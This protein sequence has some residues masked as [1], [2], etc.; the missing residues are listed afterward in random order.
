MYQ[1]PPPIPRGSPENFVNFFRRV[2]PCHISKFQG[3]PLCGIYA[4]MAS[5][6][7]KTLKTGTNKAHSY[8]VHPECVICNAKDKKGEPIRLIVDKYLISHSYPETA[9]MLLLYGMDVSYKTVE[10]HM[11]KHSPYLKEVKST[12]LQA[13]EKSA[14]SRVE[15]VAEEYIEAE[16]VIQEIITLGG[17]KVRAGEIEVDGKLLISALKEQGSRKQQG[18]LRDLL[19]DLD[20]KRFGAVEEG[21]LLEG[22]GEVVESSLG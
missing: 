9:K 4:V 2:T 17:R 13:V 15:T 12:I 7:V 3:P 16:D 6:F 11:K 10:S 18:R 8:L 20:K 22:S 1:Y 14:L 19:D 5:K 21:K